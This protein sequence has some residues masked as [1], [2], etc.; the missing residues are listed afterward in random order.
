MSKKSSIKDFFSKCNSFLRIWSHLLKKSLMENVIFFIFF[1]LYYFYLFIHLFTYLFIYLLFVYLFIY[2]FILFIYL[3]N[4]S[5]A[6][7]Y[8]WVVHNWNEIS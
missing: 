7:T 1:C 6:T 8:K 5:S 4:T 3:F 2:L